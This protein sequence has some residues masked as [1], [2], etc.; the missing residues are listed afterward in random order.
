M[1][2]VYKSRKNP[3]PYLDIGV[4]SMSTR[5]RLEVEGPTLLGEI[6]GIFIMYLATQA[7]LRRLLRSL[8]YAQLCKIFYRF[9]LK[10]NFFVCLVTGSDEGRR[11]TAAIGPH[12]ESAIK[13]ID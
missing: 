5:I 13:P 3:V 8:S 12:P 9:L 4:D 11:Q 2:A 6:R 7:A 10:L 1:L